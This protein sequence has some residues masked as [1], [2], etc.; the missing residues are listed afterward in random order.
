MEFET[1]ED[2]DRLRGGPVF[3]LSCFPFVIWEYNDEKLI[4]WKENHTKPS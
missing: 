2:F 4:G 3:D 1:E